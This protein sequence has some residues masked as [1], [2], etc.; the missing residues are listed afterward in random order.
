MNQEDWC[1]RT[2]VMFFYTHPNNWLPRR[3][4]VLQRALLLSLILGAAVVMSPGPGTA[5]DSRPSSQAAALA[6]PD[7]AGPDVQPPG[8]GSGSS[9]PAISDGTVEALPQ[10]RSQNLAAADRQR[11]LLMVLILR[12]AG[13]PVSAFPK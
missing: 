10:S 2:G 3:Q 6:P 11:R 5:E 8:A 13:S 4:T 12:G 9:A 1:K 7:R